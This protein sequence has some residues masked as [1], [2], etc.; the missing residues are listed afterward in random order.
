M[1]EEGEEGEETV[2]DQWRVTS[3]VVAKWKELRDQGYSHAKV[4]EMTGFSRFT[5]MGHIKDYIP[6]CKRE[7][8]IAEPQGQQQSPLGSP[9]GGDSQTVDETLQTGRESVDIFENYDEFMRKLDLILTDFGVPMRIREVVIKSVMDT[10][11][12][13]T[14]EGFL[15]FLMYSGFKGMSPQ[16]ASIITN[17]YF[18]A[19]EQEQ[20]R[21]NRG[22]YQ[23]PQQRAPVG[24]GYQQPYGQPYAQP[25]QSRYPQG[26]LYGM[27]RCGEQIPPQPP[28]KVY[29]SEEME[30]VFQERLRMQEKEQEVKDLKKKLDDLTALIA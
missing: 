20:D 24:P 9:P 19:I 2:R 5:V 26:P 16:K 1:G 13:Q 14:R 30:K 11:Q 25:Y 4:A 17:R 3:E 8:E 27:Q 23:Q 7:N 28:Q 10:P 29:T 15:N 6:K 18:G 12:Y 21:I 22:L